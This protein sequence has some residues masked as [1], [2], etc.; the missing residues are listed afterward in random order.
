M[1]KIIDVEVK[2]Q[3]A[4]LEKC[5]TDMLCVGF[6]S[7]EKRLD[8]TNQFL[9]KRIGGL[10]EKIIKLGDFRGEEQTTE[11][12]YTGNK[13]A[14]QRLMLAG[15]GKKK[16]ATLD[17]LRKAAAC[18]AN[19]AVTMKVKNLCLPCTGRLEVRL[20][21]RRWDRVVRKVLISAVID[22]MNM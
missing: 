11:V 17:T 18:A 20:K 21:R 3:K 13:I 12:L 8:K 4:E 16:K 14:A 19:V 9:D 2:V 7:G 5:R 22:T 6:F 15:L 10:I 1:K